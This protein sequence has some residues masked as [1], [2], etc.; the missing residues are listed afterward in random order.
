MK[1]YN[2]F[3]NS[4]QQPYLKKIRIYIIIVH[5]IAP[6]VILVKLIKI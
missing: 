4:R 1:P 5:N 3:N 6:L 2:K